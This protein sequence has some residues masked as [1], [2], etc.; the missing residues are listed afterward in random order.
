MNNLI[1]MISKFFSAV[2]LL[3]LLSGNIHA[4]ISQNISKV[5]VGDAKEKSELNIQVELYNTNAEAV[6]LY[7]KPVE[8]S[9]YREAEM[10]LIGTNAGY[11]IPADEV[12]PP[13][14]AYYIQVR[15]NDGSFE[16]Y[17]LGAPDNAP[18]S[19]IMVSIPQDKDSELI[20]LS[21][22][23]KGENI[24]EDEF[25]ISISLLRASEKV[26]KEATKIYLGALDLTPNL[27]FAGDM[28]LYYPDNLP[29]NVYMGSNQLR[30]ELYDQEGNLYHSLVRNFIVR[31]TQ[32]V[33]LIGGKFTY[34]GNVK[35]ESR[36]EGFSGTGQNLWYNNIGVDAS[37]GWGNWKFNTKVYAT[38][39][40]KKYLQPQN[41]Y[42]LGIES[43]WLKVRVGDIYPVFPNLIMSGRRIRGATGRLELG[44]FNLHV[45]YGQANRAVEGALLQ[46]YSRNNAPI[47]S[48]II[49]IDSVK[50]GNPYGEVNTGTYERKLFALRPYFGK[51]E[52]FQWGLSYLHSKDDPKSIEFAAR[53]KENVVF[54]SDLLVAFDDRNILFTGQAAVSL[55]NTDISGGTLTDAE[56]DS[57]FGTSDYINIDPQN[58]KD[59]K[60][61]LGSFMTVNQFIGPLNPEKM[62]SLASEAQLQLNYF[63]NN[64]SGKYIYR[65]NEY[66][67]FGQSYLRLDVKGY[68]F[69]DRIRLFDNRLFITVAYE[70]LSDN[71]QKT[72]I[73]TTTFNKFTGTVSIFPR[74]NM[75]NITLGYNRFENQSDITIFDP[76]YGLYAVDDI[77][78]RYFGQFNY[79]F[80]WSIRH[81]AVLNV[82]ISDRKDRSLRNSN[83]KNFTGSLSLA[84]DWRKNFTSFFSSTYYTSE[85]IAT[86][87][88]YFAFSLGGKYKLMENRLILTGSIGP[89][90]GDFKRQS[91]EFLAQYFIMPNFDV[92][93]QSRVFHIPSQGT[94]TIVGVNTRYGF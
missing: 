32:E 39:E 49:G 12:V 94:N 61:Y 54:G 69:S 64:I 87:F 52:N 38:S 18:P 89:S 8:A 23:A 80:I 71:L 75:P 92:T 17:P 40:E 83:A 30:V 51:G 41:R 81:N 72:K 21:P 85:I 48:N 44:A 27:I 56:I 74:I 86:Q 45:I 78:D 33:E 36:N 3:S 57:I 31:Q 70:S 16:N 1:Q 77:T 84:S 28:I 11:T 15:M 25:F 5:I 73:T 62:S 10:E 24:P 88:N 42:Y 2:V 55:F 6:L 58:V 47:A 91:F 60:Q 29:K 46:T 19:R 93:F 65:G 14:L 67:S 50:Y 22:G 4:Q 59:I 63:H 68:E 20:F 7:Y 35:A 53:P 34:R 76:N 43:D 37:A 66:T 26:K 9:E 90:F 13:F 79:D 82:S